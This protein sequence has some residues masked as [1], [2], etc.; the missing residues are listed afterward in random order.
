MKAIL[1]NFID[2]ALEKSYLTVGRHVGLR[3]AR[4]REE[5]GKKRQNHQQ[6]CSMGATAPNKD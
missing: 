5:A 4:S 2:F 3:K 6:S 1:V